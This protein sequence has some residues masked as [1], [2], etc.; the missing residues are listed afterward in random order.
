MHSSSTLL[1]VEHRYSNP[2]H[3]GTKELKMKNVNGCNKMDS[4]LLFYMFLNEGYNTS[5]HSKEIAFPCKFV[6]TKI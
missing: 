2:R 5:M 6:S 4:I 3:V 1:P